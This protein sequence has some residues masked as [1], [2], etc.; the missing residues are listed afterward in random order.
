MLFSNTIMRSF[1]ASASKLSNIINK[2]PVNKYRSLFTGCLFDFLI[3][4]QIIKV[5]D[6]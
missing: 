1:Y 5:S 4:I 6:Y 2:Q 3:V